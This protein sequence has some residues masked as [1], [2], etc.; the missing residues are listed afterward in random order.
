IVCKLLHEFEM[1]HE[2]MIPAADLA[3]QTRRFRTRLLIVELVT[4]IYILFLY[5]MKPPHE[6][7]VPPGAAEFTICDRLKSDFLLFGNQISYRFIFH[8]LQFA[9]G[10]TASKESFSRFLQFLRT[11]EAPHIIESERRSSPSARLIS[12]CHNQPL[13][14]KFDIATD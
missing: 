2:G 12:Y 10:N 13:L 5:T 4:A 7:K 1:F 8:C 14:R 11:Q 9:F 6:V 3:S